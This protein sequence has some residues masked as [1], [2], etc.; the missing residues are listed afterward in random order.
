MTVT[1]LS[2][3]Y[4]GNRSI[5]Q[6]ILYNFLPCRPLEA[7]GDVLG[8]LRGGPVVGS[9]SRRVM[10]ILLPARL[11]RQRKTSGGIPWRAAVRWRPEIGRTPK[12]LERLSYPVYAEET[13]EQA[14]TIIAV[15]R[16][17]AIESFGRQGGFDCQPTVRDP[18]PKAEAAVESVKVVSGKRP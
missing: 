10:P 1:T 8:F 2:L 16:K 14:A 9:T 18:A 13:E 3:S 12:R 17:L 6:S 5:P 4:A 11:K 7:L 15:L